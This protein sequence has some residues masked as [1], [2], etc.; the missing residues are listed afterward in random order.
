M[1]LPNY[2]SKSYPI[3]IKVGDALDLYCLW[4][5]HPASLHKSLFSHILALPVSKM[6]SKV[7]SA[8]PTPINPV[9]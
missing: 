2:T 7:L 3:S 6:T 4:L 1:P 9:Y 5:R 8:D